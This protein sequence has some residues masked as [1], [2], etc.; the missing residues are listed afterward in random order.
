MGDNL[1]HP[2]EANQRE[3]MTGKKAQSSARFV[4]TALR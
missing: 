2:V 3:R 1:I 4:S